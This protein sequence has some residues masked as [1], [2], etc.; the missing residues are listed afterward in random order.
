MRDEL[1]TMKKGLAKLLETTAKTPLVDRTGELAGG[2]TSLVGLMDRYAAS[3]DGSVTMVLNTDGII[4][5]HL[6]AMT[7]DQAFRRGR[8]E[9]VSGR[10]SASRPRR[11]AH[12]RFHQENGYTL[13]SGLIPVETIDHF[14]AVL[15]KMREKR[16]PLKRLN[17]KREA[18][19][20][21]GVFTAPIKDLHAFSENEF[22]QELS[23]AAN[24]ILLGDDVDALLRRVT[25]NGAHVLYRSAY[26][27][28]S[29]TT[30]HQD[31]YYFDSS[32]SGQLR[33]VW[34]ALEDM[35]PDGDRF[36][37]VPRLFNVTDAFP[38]RSLELNAVNDYL[39]AKVHGPWRDAVYSPVLKKGDVIIWN[40]LLVHGSL[41]GD[42]RSTRKSLIGH[43]TPA[44]HDIRC[45]VDPQMTMATM[46]KRR[47][48]GRPF[49]DTEKSPSAGKA[50]QPVS[51]HAAN[52]FN[53]QA[54]HH[55]GAP[56]HPAVR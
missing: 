21:D 40:S 35:K 4:K 27:E 30:A 47:F 16:Q 42:T 31:Y 8:P 32:P 50:D 9:S 18:N 11:A 37:L 56:R 36:F 14:N 29:R 1:M 44:N 17:E 24:A 55:T 13:A 19:G 3:V 41:E 2:A 26:F 46:P 39:D 43:F 33:G 15:E 34:V 38:S 48:N 51:P 20:A 53:R 25:R 7:D 22:E 49:F 28:Y 45:F 52:R 6:N 5:N 12:L 10:V 23:D 54:H